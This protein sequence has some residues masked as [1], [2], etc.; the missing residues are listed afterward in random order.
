VVRPTIAVLAIALAATA[1]ACSGHRPA[2]GDD[3]PHADRFGVYRARFTEPGDGARKAKVFLFAALPDR[4]HAEVLPPV[5]GPVL[6]IDGGSGRLAVTVNSRD[7]AWVGEAREDVLETILG[8]PVTLE[9][10]VGALLQGS[11]IEGAVEITRT[12][13]TGYGLPRRF[14]MSLAG[15]ELLLE[16]Q[17][18][19]KRGRGGYAIGTGTPPPGV[20]TRS[21]EELVSEGGPFFFTEE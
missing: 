21:L 7:A 12:P 14:S 1:V 9:A 19:R 16:L 8:F 10:L 13:G 11:A 15:R 4:L 2:D 20:E 18:T 3:G 17:R 6:I 5:G